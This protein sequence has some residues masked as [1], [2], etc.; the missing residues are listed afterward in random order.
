MSEST[1]SQNIRDIL[2]VALS[3]ELCEIALTHRSFAFENGGVPHNE[4]LEFLG[5][6]VLG[7]SVTVMLFRAFPELSEGELAK[8]RA[9]LVST[10]AL[11]E[12]AIA[13]GL[14]QFI[15]FGRGEAASGGA[16]KASI[17]A[18]T[19]EALIGATYLE[20]GQD[21][22]TE[23]VSRLIE[24]LMADQERFGEAMDPKTSLQE[25]AA[26]HA[27]EP[28]R[29]EIRESGPDHSKRFVALVS[30]N[31][32]SAEGEGTSKKAAEMAAARA[33]WKALHD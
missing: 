13:I 8:R 6:S 21:A 23:L 22:A 2:R 12:I 14:G 25:Y 16:D 30:I 18:D 20:L 5:D 31:G 11:A 3:D 27:V 28:P 24:P 9:A 4:R 19:I 7:Q 10:A 15:R 1:P 33:V 29:Y 26:R 17:L 32:V